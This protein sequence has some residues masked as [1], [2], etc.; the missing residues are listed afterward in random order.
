MNSYTQ[1]LERE[2]NRLRNALAA[3]A[4]RWRDEA[5]EMDKSQCDI[6][7]LVRRDMLYRC[8]EELHQ[9]SAMAFGRKG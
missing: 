7:D 3:L 1:R 2:N 4:Q 8:A 9:V 5:R 6:E